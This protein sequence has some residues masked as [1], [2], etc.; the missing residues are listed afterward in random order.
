[1]DVVDFVIGST[2]DKSFD[3]ALHSQIGLNWEITQI[4]SQKRKTEF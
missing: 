1:M 4:G 2:R 3:E